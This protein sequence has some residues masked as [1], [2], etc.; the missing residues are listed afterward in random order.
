MSIDMMNDLEAELEG[1][2]QMTDPEG[3]DPFLGNVISGIGNALGGL[4]GEGEGE[5]EDELNMLADGFDNEVFNENISFEAALTPAAAN[6]LME[7]MAAQ[8]A[9]SESE[10][11]ADQFLPII[12]ALAAKALPLLAKAGPALAKKVVPQ[13]ARGVQTIGK[14]L[15][16][17]PARRQLTRTLPTIARNAAANVLQQAANGRPVTGQTVARALAGSTAQ[18]LRNPQ[19]R[20]GCVRRNRRIAS[21][22]VRR[23]CRNGQCWNCSR[24]A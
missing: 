1:Q 21:G 23:I 13:L 2:L 24:T 7:V 9:E 20:R 22:T 10:E 19:V 14:R 6:A 4:F 5:E 15:W 12:G 3:G 17:S 18:V 8:A 16:N 11:E